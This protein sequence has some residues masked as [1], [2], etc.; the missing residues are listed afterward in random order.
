MPSTIEPAA[1]APESCD[2]TESEL[3]NESRELERVMMRLATDYP[4]LSSRQIRTAVNV[5]VHGFDGARV[6]RFVPLLVERLARQ[7]LDHVKKGQQP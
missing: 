7:S 2:Q 1:T 5:A 4:T 6:R 3:L